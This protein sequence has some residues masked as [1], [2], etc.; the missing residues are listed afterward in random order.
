MKG[1]VKTQDESEVRVE[2]KPE[3]NAFHSLTSCH[4]HQISRLPPYFV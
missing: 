1:V 4:L 2:L 3:L